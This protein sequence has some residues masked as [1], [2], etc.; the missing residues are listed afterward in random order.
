MS[1]KRKINQEAFRMTPRQRRHRRVRG[2]VSGT[3]QRPR[4]NV[5]RSSLHIYAQIIDD[6]QGVTLAAAGS[7]EAALREQL[8][9]EES[10]K[11]TAAI[12]VGKLVAERAKEKGVAQVAFD[13]GGNRYHGRV[14]AL[15]D[16]ARE[17]GLDF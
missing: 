9:G 17:A 1:Q 13:R 4:L 14:K 10:T 5:F 3:P 11:T 15:A 12:A 16:A 8:V 7:H 2:K 6:T